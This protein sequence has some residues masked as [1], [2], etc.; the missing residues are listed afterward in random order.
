MGDITGSGCM[1]GTSITVFCGAARIAAKSTDS[2]AS[3]PLVQGDILLGAVAGL[4]VYT[5]AGEK[6]GERDDVRGPNT[7]RSAFIDEMYHVRG[8]DVKRMGKVEVI[9]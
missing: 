1:T 4:L 5:V 8:D 7:F 9:R 2:P 6:A 3:S